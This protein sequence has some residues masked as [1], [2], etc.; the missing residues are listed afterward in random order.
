MRILKRVVGAL[1]LSTLALVAGSASASPAAPKAGVEYQVLSAP[2]PTES[3]KKIEITEFF[4]YYCPHCHSFEPALAAWVKKQGDTIVFKRVHIGRDESVAPQ[5]KLFYTLEAMGLLS[6]QMHN[7][8][9]DEMHLAHNRLN[10]DE[11]VFDFIVKQGVDK[12]K[13]VDTYRSFGVAGRVR[14]ATAMMAAYQI[15]SWPMLA[16]D[17][18]FITS[19]SMADDEKKTATTEA[20]LHT[21]VLQVMDV[22][23]AKAKAEKK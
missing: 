4:A 13:F 3:G 11:Q 20:Q 6:E 10:R 1:A 17:G 9:F 14:K 23:L 15:D 5:Q 19:P 16:V 21:E 18:R 8:I 12:Q 2:Q 7:K 22:L